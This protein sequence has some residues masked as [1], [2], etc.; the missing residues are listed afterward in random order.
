MTRIGPVCCQ[1]AFSEQPQPS[2]FERVI[3]LGFFDGTT[4][5]IAE[6]SICARAH[7]YGLVA[8]DEDQQWRAFAFGELQRGVFPDV[9]AACSSLGT[10]RWPIWVPLFTGIDSADRASIV[11]SI[12]RAAGHDTGIDRLLVAERI[13]REIIASWSVARMPTPQPNEL[14]PPLRDYLGRLGRR[15]VVPGLPKEYLWQ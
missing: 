8:W 3:S 15:F 11:E 10:P 2:P 6:C 14:A 7:R 1:I 12:D 9:I 4:S 13:E 5:G